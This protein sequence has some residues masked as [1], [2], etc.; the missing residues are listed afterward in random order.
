MLSFWRRPVTPQLVMSSFAI[1]ALALLAFLA[2]GMAQKGVWFDEQWSKWMSSR[3]LGLADAARERW[4]QDVHPPLFYLFNWSAAALIGDAVVTHRWLNFLWVAALAG[5][6]AYVATVR[7]A[8]RPTLVVAGLLMLS[9]RDILLF[10]EY[11]S[12]ALILCASAALILLLGEMLHRVEDLAWPQD[13]VLAVMLVVTILVALNLHYVTT[14][15]CGLTIAV[16]TIDQMRSRRWRW[17]ALLAGAAAFAMLFVLAALLAEREYILPAARGFWLITPFRR[18]VKTVLEK[19]FYASGLN[20]VAIACLALVVAQR[21]GVMATRIADTMDARTWRFVTLAAIAAVLS[22]VFLLALNERKSIIHPRY[23]TALTAI[24]IVTIAV[25]VSRRIVSQRWIHLL[26]VANAAIAASW[27]IGSIPAQPSWDTGARMIAAQVRQ[28]PSTLVYSVSM[29]DAV[30]YR[31][32]RWLPN[33]LPFMRWAMRDLGRQYGL[34]Q[35]HLIITRPGEPRRRSPDGCPTLLWIENTFELHVPKT[36]LRV[37]LA[38]DY[39]DAAQARLAQTNTGAI[40]II[41]PLAAASAD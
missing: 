28:C 35:E 30:A 34:Q 36:L 39:A 38:S 40:V 18:A 27:W 29:A 9:T 15:I 6:G 31:P 33:D 8:M 24:I 13:R 22:C 41:P 37:G 26:F 12:Y 32:Y 1:L 5:V 11:R 14:L 25:V 19:F 23:L 2:V 4:F 20:I 7:P 10:G 3:E 21:A 17:A 16:F